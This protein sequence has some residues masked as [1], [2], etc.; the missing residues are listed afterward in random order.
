MSFQDP[1]EELVYKLC[2]RSFLS[3]W[4]YA[5]PRRTRSNHELCDVLVACDRDVVIFSVKSC[6][7][8]ASEE[9]VVAV[10]RWWKKAVEAPIR[11]IYGAER[12]L[13]QAT[14]VTRSDGTQGLPLPPVAQRRVHRVS[15]SL[16]SNG[17]VPF[18]SRDFG[19]GF[20]HVFDDAFLNIGLREL[21]T[22]T[23]FLG[24]LR[25]K[26]NLASQGPGLVIQGGEENLLALYLFHGRSFPNDLP[27]IVVGDNWNR[28]VA[29]PAYARRVTAD[30]PSYSWD[31]LIEFLCDDIL[32]GR[33]EFGNILSDNEMV[34]RYM[35]R[36]NRFERRILSDSLKDF[37]ELARSGKVRA[38]L[39]PSPSGVVYVF[40][41]APANYDRRA[42]IAELGCRCFIARNE[43]PEH[44]IVIGIGANIERAPK[45]YATDL[46][47][48]VCP[49]WSQE[50]AECAERMKAELGFFQ[51]PD[52]KRIQRDEYPTE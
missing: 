12:D 29:N 7:F 45:G 18:S 20:V 22:I 40:F 50:Q 23:D 52:S 32:G 13:A 33:M 4:S 10:K 6:T 46:C 42:R 47:L 8:D 34:V 49:D 26:E 3:L 5:N 41:N 35:A 38:R 44:E 30:A 28:F 19:K 51:S 36:E 15:V 25:A 48:L 27:V 9:S 21:D 37:R 1:T 11:Q 17:F 16:G 39:S 14:H 2:Q 24:Y 31:G 43:F